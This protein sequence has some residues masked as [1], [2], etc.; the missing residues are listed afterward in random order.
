MASKTKLVPTPSIGLIPERDVG[1]RPILECIGLG[2]TFGGLKAVEDFNLIIGRTEIAGL[3][4][5]NGAGKTTV[6]NLLTKVYQ[7]THGTILLDG[8]DT[9]NMDTAHVN[10]AGICHVPHHIQRGGSAHHDHH[11]EDGLVDL[12]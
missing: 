2:I 6:F 10:R 12:A 1:K 9:H 3:I 11:D 4:G 5:P 8:K 7:P